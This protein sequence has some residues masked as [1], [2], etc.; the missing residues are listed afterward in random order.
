M[1][2]W[3]IFVPPSPDSSKVDVGSM[4]C[5]DGTET[6]LEA[7][8]GRVCPLG[9]LFMLRH[10]Y[11]LA[12]PFALHFGGVSLYSNTCIIKKNRTGRSCEASRLGQVTS[13]A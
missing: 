1:R 12:A 11:L 4:C 2:C 7:A 10:D 6:G 9:H 8:M 3:V 13:S 5:P